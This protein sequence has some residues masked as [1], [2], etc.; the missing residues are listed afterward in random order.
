MQEDLRKY[1]VNL[2]KKVS[3]SRKGDD[4]CKSDGRRSGNSVL[5]WVVRSA[6]VRWHRTAP[7]SVCITMRSAGPGRKR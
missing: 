6:E 2:P 1:L 7:T 5:L 4:A 3:M